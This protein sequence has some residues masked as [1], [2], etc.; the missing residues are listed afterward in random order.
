VRVPR[1][2]GGHR[3]D[4]YTRRTR[5]SR[6]RDN[7]R[8]S[9]VK[10]IQRAVETGV[11]KILYTILSLGLRNTPLKQRLRI[12]TLRSLLIIPYGDAIGD[13]VVASGIWR[14]IK[15][16]NPECRVGVITSERNESLLTG[17][18][19]VDMTFPFSGRADT[20]N[21]RNLRKA[22][23]ERF[24]VILN[25][26]SSHQTDYGLIANYISNSATKATLHHPRSDLYRLLFNHIGTRPR[27]SVH[28]SHASLE[29][30][31]E[32]VTT[33]THFQLHEAWPSLAISSECREAVQRQLQDLGVRGKYVVIHLQA[34]TSYR[35][36]GITNAL[37]FAA[38]LNQ[39]V[40]E[41]A[42]L[43]TASPT[44]DKVD[45]AA[46]PPTVLY[47]HNTRN[48]LEMAALLETAALVVCP[49]TSVVHFASAVRTPCVALFPNAT[50]L[51]ME[52]LPVGVPSRL[53]VPA[54]KGDPVSTINAVLVHE[55]AM[56]LLNE[57][58]K[59][60]QTQ[61]DPNAIQHPAYQRA[62]GSLPFS[63]FNLPQ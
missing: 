26:H 36:W 8:P 11:R 45:T 40:P 19:D 54:Q 20:R 52:W 31:S 41:Y 3:V 63:D 21:Y 5:R 30:L 16:R 37:E 62:N 18:A 55:A 33:D 32:V 35:E 24:D 44:Y 38:L 17:D 13:L 22:R 53:L 1:D 46:L 47:F 15:R 56:S 14:A 50:S 39:S 60:T 7:Y 9:L 34:A 42:V 57:E 48:L 29:L 23:N 6:N 43:L 61:L 28:I 27:H 58:W 59:S 12:E 49:D 4:A 25:I 51:P 2:T 10:K